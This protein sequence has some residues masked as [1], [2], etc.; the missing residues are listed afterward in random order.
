MGKKIWNTKI[1]IKILCKQEIPPGEV[2]TGGEIK[3]E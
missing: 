2:L 3:Y 1:A